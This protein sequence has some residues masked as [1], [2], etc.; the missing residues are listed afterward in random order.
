MCLCECVSVNIIM[1]T[2]I[3][4]HAYI[5]LCILGCIK[6]PI[7]LKTSDKIDLPSLKMFLLIEIVNLLSLNLIGLDLG[8]HRQS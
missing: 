1:Y 3:H 6:R 2:Y 4:E 8:S 7:I 5:Y